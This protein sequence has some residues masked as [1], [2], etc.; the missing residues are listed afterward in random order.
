MNTK[1]ASQK[2]QK[3]IALFEA[4]GKET[5]L[6]WCTEQNVGYNS[7][8]TWRKRLKNA[9]TPK[10]DQ[11]IPAFVELQDS[12]RPHSGI[13]IHHHGLIFTLSKDFDE[14]ALLRC[15]KVLEQ[16]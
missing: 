1:D 10:N 16:V 6:A 13:E 12:P 2:W 5:A 4:S 9:P 3:L 15:I 8:V 7:F 14:A 11:P